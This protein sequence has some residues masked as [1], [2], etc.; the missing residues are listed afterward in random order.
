MGLDGLVPRHVAAIDP[1]VPG[2]PME[3]LERERGL[4]PGSAIKLASNENP[5]GPSPRAVEALR[6]ESERA[7]WYPDGS[8]W[9]LRRALS[10]HHGVPFEEVAVGAGSNELINLLALG[11]VGANEEVLLSS[12]SFLCYEL[13]C[14][15]AGVSFRSVPMREHTVDLEAMAAAISERTKLIFLAN[16][17]NPT[18]TY[19]SRQTLERFLVRLPPRIILVLD[20]AY[21]EYVE[22][23]DYPDS[24]EYRDSIPRLVTL[25]TFSKIHGLAGV[26]VGYAITDASIV[27][28]LDRV[29]APFNV[30]SLAQ[31][32]AI[33]ALGDAAH[34]ARS[35]E[36][37]RLERAK[38]FTRLEALGCRPVPS[39]ANFLLVEPSRPASEVYGALLARGIIV[40]PVGNYGL[41]NHLRI[42][43]GTAEANHRLCVALEE[44]LS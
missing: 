18:G 38:L 22:A 7:H 5:L 17:N 37:N 27:Q 35:A 19:F 40:R 15:A 10:R 4:A 13:A 24:L 12:C 11:F 36:L 25:R 26:R 33:A 6:A 30:S 39:Q 21:F 16:P 31:S 1:Y 32:A 42:S 34:V 2:K 28:F 44:I 20:E 3:E 29:R 14:R 9:A 43:I 8:S 41:D 23:T